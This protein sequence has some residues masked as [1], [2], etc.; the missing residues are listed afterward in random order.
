M[1]IATA[2]LL[3]GA[4]FLLAAT[5]G[6]GVLATVARAVTSGF[7]P[8]ALVVL[9]VVLGDLVFLLLAIFGLDVLAAVLGDLF[10]VVKI[11]GA[12]Y[13]IWLGIQLWRTAAP[14]SGA[15]PPTPPWHGSLLSGLTITLGNPKVILFYLGLLPTFVDLHALHAADIAW[16][17]LIVSGVLGGTLLAYA[18]AGARTRR[19]LHNPRAMRIANRSAGG[20]MIVAGTALA[21]RG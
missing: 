7:A 1:T 19:L 13:L 6:P 9:G 18:G 14:A 2:I 16:I 5:P 12:G 20:A 8:A 11:A 10:L 21:V 3:A 15:A 17:A 4:M